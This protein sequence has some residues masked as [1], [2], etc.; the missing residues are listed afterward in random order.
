MKSSH[1][2]AIAV[3]LFSV[4][5]FLYALKNSLMLVEVI[6]SGTINGIP[7]STVFILTTT[8]SPLAA[9]ILL[10]LFP[11]SVTNLILKPETD[12]PVEPMGPAPLLTVLIISIGI[13]T[14]FYAIIDS[15]YWLNFWH[16][17]SRNQV[18][19]GPIPLG[20]PSKANMIATAFELAIS[21][22]LVFKAKT[23]AFYTLKF[24][25]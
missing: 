22:A 7:A 8:L 12:L 15:I 25:K 9:A 6:S 1:Y 14:L 11:F 13:Y 2:L 18:L 23:L 10:W 16:L 17:N 19:S 3:R 5:L 4:A 20:D 24:S 21:M